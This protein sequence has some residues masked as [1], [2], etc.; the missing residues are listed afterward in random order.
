MVE[1]IMEKAPRKGKNFWI[2]EKFGNFPVFLGLLARTCIFSGFTDAENY[3]T[4][5]SASTSLANTLCGANSEISKMLKI[6][7]I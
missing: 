3:L 1:E 2:N 6:S 7:S 4:I 5:F